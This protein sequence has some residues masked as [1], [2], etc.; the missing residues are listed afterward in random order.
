MSSSSRSSRPQGFKQR[1]LEEVLDLECELC[2]VLCLILA[3]PGTPIYAF[4]VGAERHSL[5]G[6]SGLR[7]T[8]EVRESLA[9]LAIH[10][11]SLDSSGELL[12]PPNLDGV[13]NSLIKLGGGMQVRMS[14][15]L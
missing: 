10:G 9:R 13:S 15:N 7:M 11:Q 3:R 1:R 6:M 14:H 4:R 8:E 5:C 12:L 2:Q